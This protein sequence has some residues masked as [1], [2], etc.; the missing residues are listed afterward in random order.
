MSACLQTL[1]ESFRAKTKEYEKKSAKLEKLLNETQ[2]QLA[3]FLN[4][5]QL[6][7]LNYKKMTKWA[8]ET[9]IKALKFR[10]MLGKISNSLKYPLHLQFLIIM[11]VLY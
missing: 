4:S 3:T 8:P 11:L 7:S 5:D 2:D 9:V 1:N 10:Y 6:K